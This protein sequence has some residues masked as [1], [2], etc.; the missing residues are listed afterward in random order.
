[1]SA[2]RITC[3]SVVLLAALF[4]ACDDDEPGSAA[5]G[6]GETGAGGSND[7]GSAGAPA[8]TLN[9]CLDR[10]GELQRPPSGG[11]PCELLPPDFGH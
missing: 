7:A 4:S 6:G 9:P 2:R 10:P 8:S 11:L 3:A 1:M 5:G